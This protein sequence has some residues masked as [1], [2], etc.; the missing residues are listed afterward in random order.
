MVL[1]KSP[2]EEGVQ[3]SIHKHPHGIQI[4]FLT[5][6]KFVECVEFPSQLG[7]CV[8]LDLSSDSRNSHPQVSFSYK[9]DI[10][11]CC[12]E[13]Y[14]FQET[15]LA[16]VQIDTPVTVNSFIQAMYIDGFNN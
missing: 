5:F 12:D 4:E 1:M 7:R 9:L 6:R 14:K 2:Y 10:E 8:Q 13:E 3:N 15:F 16:Q 11:R